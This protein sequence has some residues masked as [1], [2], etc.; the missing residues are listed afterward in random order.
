MKTCP[1][2]SSA[3]KTDSD[4]GIGG[5]ELV[6]RTKDMQT[7]FFFAEDTTYGIGEYADK[8]T[9]NPF[10]AMENAYG[11]EN[12]H[13]F[14]KKYALGFGLTTGQNAFSQVDLF[15]KAVGLDGIILTK[16]DGTAK[17]GFVISLADQLGVPVK[18][19]GI[20]E[21]IDDIEEFDSESFVE[22]LF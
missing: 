9:L 5:M 18:Y 2:A 8:T 12:T 11:F 20:G 17:G 6:S 1:T 21:G 7:K 16:L 13:Y 15:N 3:T 14:G 19:V 22:A 10:M 4:Y